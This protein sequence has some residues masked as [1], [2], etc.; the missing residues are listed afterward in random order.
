MGP[1]RRSW[2]CLLLALVR[3]SFSIR[4]KAERRSTSQ[5][6]YAHE[7]HSTLRSCRSYTP[8]LRA[9]IPNSSKV[10]EQQQQGLR[11]LA[12]SVGGRRGRRGN[13][14]LS[15]L[16][17]GLLSRLGWN[18]EG[19]TGMYSESSWLGNETEQSAML[20]SVS[21]EPNATHSHNCW[22]LQAWSQEWWPVVQRAQ[23]SGQV[24]A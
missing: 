23:E 13:W 1:R 2:S 14:L 15:R 11:R 6:N 4:S 17:S 10:I 24:P 21:K 3:R 5:A 9:F 18:L 8:D 16:V 12:R 22:P 19:N 7:C 20:G